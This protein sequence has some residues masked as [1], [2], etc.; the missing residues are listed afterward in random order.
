MAG[1]IVLGNLMMDVIQ[2][3]F[4]VPVRY[5]IYFTTG[6]FASAN[7]LLRDIVGG[8]RNVEAANNEDNLPARIVVVLDHG[9]ERAHPALV[10]SIAA[11]C[12]EHRDVLTLARPVLVV[13]GGEEI[14]DERRYT[15]QIVEAINAA[16]LCRHSYVIAVGGGAVLDAAGFAAATAHRGVRLVRVPTTVLSQD[17]SAVGVKNGINA[18][19]KKNYL[20][21]FTPPFAV[22]NDAG[23]L[24]TLS[25]RDW[26]GGTTEAVKAALIRDPRFFELIEEHAQAL[27]DRDL[28]VMAKVIRHSAML[29][30]RHI[31]TG[32]DPFEHGSSRP[33]DFG[34]WA[35]HKLEQVTKHRLGHGEAV[36]IGIAL[37]TTYSY[38]A[39]L[40]PEASWRRIVELLAAL[41]VPVY[42]AALDERLDDPDHRDCILRGLD[43][44]QEHL[45]GRLTIMLL[46]EIG[47]PID[48]HEVRADLI[49]QSI[50]SIKTLEAERRRSAAKK[51]S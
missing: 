40:L 21:T 15:D 48:V 47:Q 36:G 16:S 24:S 6:V 4:L 20:G 5:P 2:Q 29:H 7:R 8:G 10:H 34:H 3:E 17:D 26:R 44:F 32:G 25:D 22:I 18:F 45:G 38:L 23:F 9:V 35:A 49:R 27:V 43:D 41:G 51:A 14:K 13:P 50:A 30:L 1:E 33:L 46:Q 42:D 12:E 11:Y 39:G 28:Q 31:A 37:D 19:G